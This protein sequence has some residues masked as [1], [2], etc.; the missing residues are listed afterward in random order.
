VLDQFQNG[1]VGVCVHVQILQKGCRYGQASAPATPK[2]MTARLAAMDT[3][4][5]KS[6]TLMA[7]SSSGFGSVTSVAPVAGSA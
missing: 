4:K 1:G 5:M 6:R 2:T 3:P 7:P